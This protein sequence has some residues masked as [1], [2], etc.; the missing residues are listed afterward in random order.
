MAFIR[1]TAKLIKELGIQPANTPDQ[2][3][4]LFDWHANMLR[5][6][7]KKHVLFTNNQTLYSFLI[8]WTGKPQSGDFQEQ[9]RLGLFQSLM[10][11]RLAESQVEYML[12]GHTQVTITKTNNRSVLGSMN[13][14]A[15][16]IESMIS[17]KDR[18]VDAD[19]SEINRDLNRIPMGA[20][21]YQ[22][23]IAELKRRLDDMHK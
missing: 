21:A 23:S 19:L 9:F 18:L 22:Y 4:D 2:P 8:R 14:L 7:R 6:A 12:S 5:L 11:E 1:C 15:F 3:A 17:V 10:S 20:I 13:D 16:Q